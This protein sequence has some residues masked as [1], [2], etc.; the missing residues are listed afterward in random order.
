MR[1]RNLFC[2]YLILLS[3]SINAQTNT[4]KVMAWN[5]LH[6]ANDIKNGKENGKIFDFAPPKFIFLALSGFVV[7]L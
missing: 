6:G 4:F 1:K 7:G 3:T 5:I 2:V